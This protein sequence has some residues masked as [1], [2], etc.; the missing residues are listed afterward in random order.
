MD[1]LDRL[2]LFVRI[3][4]RHSFT[5]A[6]ADLGHS[7]ST[8]TEAIRMLEADL[9][10]R[11]LDRTTR[12]VS[13][14]P[15][16]QEFYRRCL[17]ILA[18]LTEAEDA[19]RGGQPRGRLRVDAHGLLTRTFLLP[20]LPEFLARHPLLDLHLGQGDRLVD[21]LREGVDCVIRA[22]EPDED[23]MIRHPL[24]VLDE[25]VIA[26]PDYLARHG[27]PSTPEALEG[28]A[29]V[30]FLSS[31]TGG[32]L[33]LDFM[34]DGRP[35]EVALPA[36]ITVNDSET[37]AALARQGLGLAQAPRY[38]FAADIAAGRLVEVLTP[39][40]PPP[41]PL[42]ALFPPSRRRTL[43]VR[44]FLAWLDELFGRAAGRPG[45]S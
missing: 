1:R 39:F 5:E 36:R 34:L 31:R 11:L 35:R 12:H 44:V 32:V 2:R 4:E 22:G 23:T 30:G 24:G 40:A 10:A 17:L 20:H 18:D 41:T 19:V 28:H 45:A 15:D 38:R 7:R 8:A 42:F 25:V 33:P 14:T 21:L 3:V 26:S 13:P 29:M 6:A 16:G 9:G 37:M 27:T 43:R